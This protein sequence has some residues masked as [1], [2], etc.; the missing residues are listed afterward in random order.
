VRQNPLS[1]ERG[2]PSR[3]IS[4]IAHKEHTRFTSL[5]IPA[6]AERLGSHSEEEGKVSRHFQYVHPS[7]IEFTWDGRGTLDAGIRSRTTGDFLYVDS[8]EVSYAEP[9]TDENFRG[10]CED[11]L[12]GGHRNALRKRLLGSRGMAP[13]V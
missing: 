13:S 10:L 7:G 5:T 9:R 12:K 11:F 6:G 8:I 1:G 4:R 2:T 3:P